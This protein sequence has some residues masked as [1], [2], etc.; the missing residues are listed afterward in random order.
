MKVIPSSQIDFQPV[1]AEGAQ[2]ACIKE[3]ITD[4][5]GAPTFAMRLFRNR[6]GGK[7]PLP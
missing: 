5:D 4:R 7:H 6:S 1:T 2:G 3:L